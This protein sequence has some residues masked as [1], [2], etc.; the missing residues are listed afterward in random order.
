[1]SYRRIR[2]TAPQLN[3]ARILDLGNAPTVPTKFNSDNLVYSGNYGLQIQIFQGTQRI[4]N[5][6]AFNSYSQSIEGNTWTYVILYWQDGTFESRRNGIRV[7]TISSSAIPSKSRALNYIGRPNEWGQPN[8]KGAV[9]YQFRIWR[10]SGDLTDE[11]VARNTYL[12]GLYHNG[13]MLLAYPMWDCGSIGRY[14]KTVEDTSPYSLT[15][16]VD[17][18]VTFECSSPASS[19]PLAAPSILSADATGP[20]GLEA[21]VS[22][23][24]GKSITSVELRC[25]GFGGPYRASK[26]VTD[27][28]SSGVTLAVPVALSFGGSYSLSCTALASTSMGTMSPASAAKTVTIPEGPIIVSQSAIIPPGDSRLRNA[29]RRVALDFAASDRTR[30]VFAAP[31]PS[32]PV[33]RRPPK[34]RLAVVFL[35]KE[36]FAYCDYDLEASVCLLTRTLSAPDGTSLG[37]SRPVEFAFASMSPFPAV[38]PDNRSPPND[39]SAYKVKPSDWRWPANYTELGLADLIGPASAVLKPAKGCTGGGCAAY[40]AQRLVNSIYSGCSLGE[41]GA[42]RPWPA[43]ACPAADPFAFM[44]FAA[45]FSTDFRHYRALYERFFYES[46]SGVLAA[47]AEEE[48]RWSSMLGTLQLFRPLPKGSNVSIAAYKDRFYRVHT[49]LLSFGA[50]SEAAAAAAADGA[51][52]QQN[53]FSMTNCLDFYDAEPASAGRTF[54]GAQAAADVQ[55]AYNG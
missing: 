39:L 36:D 53:L 17:G 14:S 52:G 23:V 46:V 21:L 28:M 32:H 48:Y 27:A 30:I 11:N 44:A 54:E 2:V 45:N 55:R 15:G 7:D 41:L 51:T 42:V 4:A 18:D 20:Q 12:S 1:M 19:S 10:P 5:Y 31:L 50:A 40:G 35:Y 6:F 47:Q 37:K 29:F 24:K 26:L 43:G 3:G 33:A 34:I 22:F 9:L 13:G 38:D 49:D 8:L 16:R 25:L